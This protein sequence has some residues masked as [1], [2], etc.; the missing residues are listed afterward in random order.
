MPSTSPRTLKEEY[1]QL[2]EEKQKRIK[3][4]LIDTLFPDEDIHVPGVNSFNKAFSREKYPKHLEFFRATKDHMFNAFI[5]ANQV[6]KTLAGSCF[7]YYH[8][9]GKYPHWWDGKRF[10][11]PVKIWVASV[12]PQQMKEAVQA[13]LF[14]NFIDKGTG[15]IPREDLLNDSGELMTWNMSGAPN[16]VGTCFVRHYDLFGHFDGYSQIEFKTYEQGRDKFQG[17]TIDVAWFD[18]EPRDYGVYSETVTRI[19]ANRGVMINTFT[20]LLGFSDVVLNFLPGGKVPPG[21]QH[22]DAPSRHVVCCGWDDVPHIDPK[23]REDAIREYLP[24]EV[25]A[26]TKGIPTKGSGAIYP[27]PEEYITVSPFNIPPYFRRAFGMDFGWTHPTSMVWG[28]QDPASGIIYLYS[29]HCLSRAT[30]PIHATAIKQRGTWIR[31]CCDPAGGG[32]SQKDGTMLIDDYSLLDIDLTPARGGQGSKEVR[33]SKVLTLLESG[34][35]KVFSSLT[36]WFEEYRI[37]RRDEQGN[38]VKQHDD[39]MD[40]TQYLIQHFDDVAIEQPDPDASVNEYE[41]QSGQ[42]RSPVTGY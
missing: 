16:V 1:A 14:G 19:I 39:L 27:V 30:P 7:A 31:G 26:R 18:E 25:E 24:H 5:A 15:I 10:D 34:Q 40:A 28:A 6:G 36:K 32:S 37:Y 4:R 23:Y 9:S 42:G 22:P 29:E 3:Y 41:F 20:P 38:I 35:L 8:A 13:K 33:I 11:K 12:T 2:L 21:G 17:G